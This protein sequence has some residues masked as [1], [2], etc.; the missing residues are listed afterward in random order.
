SSVV[1]NCENHSEPQRCRNE[2]ID[3]Q[4]PPLWNPELHCIFADLNDKIPAHNSSQ[5]GNAP[6]PGFDV[7]MIREFGDTEMFRCESNSGQV[8][9]PRKEDDGSNGEEGASEDCAQS[10][11]P[12]IVDGYKEEGRCPVELCVHAEEP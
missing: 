8:V 4:L 7:K 2:P 9:A 11:L 6:S 1:V 12:R 5:I 3:D 10:R